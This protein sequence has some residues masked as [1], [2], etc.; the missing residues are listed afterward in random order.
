[1]LKWNSDAGVELEVACL[2]QRWEFYQDLLSL[3]LFTPLILRY[4]DLYRTRCS[5]R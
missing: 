5:L 2:L 1:M 4:Q 3:S